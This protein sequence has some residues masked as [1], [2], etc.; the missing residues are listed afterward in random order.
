MSRENSSM[1][2]NRKIHRRKINKRERENCIVSRKCEVKIVCIEQWRF[3]CADIHG[4]RQRMWF[5]LYHVCIIPGRRCL[6]IH[7]FLS[8]VEIRTYLHYAETMIQCKCACTRIWYWVL[9]ATTTR[10]EENSRSRNG[11]LPIIIIAQKKKQPNDH[12]FMAILMAYSGWRKLHVIFYLPFSLGVVSV[13]CSTSS[14]WSEPWMFSRNFAAL[15]NAST[16][17]DDSDVIFLYTLF[18]SPYVPVFISSL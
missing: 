11:R 9:A 15:S 8:H 16:P 1:K 4:R 10:E 17:S 5:Y 7:I 3:S 6:F 2:T 14:S 18:S 12:Q 13:S